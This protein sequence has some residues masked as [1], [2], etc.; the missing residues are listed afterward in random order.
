MKLGA[1]KDA[2]PGS[3]PDADRVFCYAANLGWDARGALAPLGD[4]AAVHDDLDALVAADRRRRAPGDQVLVMSNGGFGGIH[5]QAARRARGAAASPR[6]VT[7]RSS[8]C[9]AS[10]ARPQSVK[11]RLLAEAVAALPAARRPRLEV[12]ALAHEPARAVAAV[13]AWVRAEVDRGRQR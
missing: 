13:A 1:M 6:G 10:A 12:P 11:A 9:T 4:K 8:T 2:L 7:T 3:L 5:E